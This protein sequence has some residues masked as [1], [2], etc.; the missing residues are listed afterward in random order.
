MMC[1]VYVKAFMYATELFGAAPCQHWNN[2]SLITNKLTTTNMKAWTASGDG[3]S[4]KG[5]G[6]GCHFGT[7]PLSRSSGP[8]R[9]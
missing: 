1:E 7:F 4:Y 5:V 9:V 2:I 6:I 8:L 3:M